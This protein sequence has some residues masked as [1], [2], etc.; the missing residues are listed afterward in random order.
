MMFLVTGSTDTHSQQQQHDA[1]HVPAIPCRPS[2][3]YRFGPATHPSDAEYPSDAAEMPRVSASAPQ[4]ELPPLDR[5]DDVAIC[6]RVYK[7][8]I[9]RSPLACHSLRTV[10]CLRTAL[11]RSDT[12][13]QPPMAERACVG[14]CGGVGV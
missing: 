13:L 6:C 9:A 10:L 3:A 5:G 8:D 2:R 11:Y 14:V 7:T 4:P 12:G 1:S